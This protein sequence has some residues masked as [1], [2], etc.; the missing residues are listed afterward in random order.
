VVNTHHVRVLELVLTA[1]CNLRCSYCYQN[2]KKARSMEW[3]TLRAS[4]DLLARSRDQKVQVLFIGGEPLLEFPLIERAV[5]YFNQIRPAGLSVEYDVITNGTLMTREHIDF[6]I[7]HDFNVQVSFD[8]VSAVQELRGKGTFAVLD[9]LL[10]GLRVQ[11]YDFFTRKIRVSLT[12]LSKTVAWLADSVD[13]FLGKGVQTILISP[14]FTAQPDWSVEQIEDLDRAFERVF[15]ACLRHFHLTGEVPLAVFQ[16]GVKDDL[17]DPASMAMCNVASGQ[18]A[19]IDVDGQVLGCVTFAE[20][21]QTFPTMFL[22]NRLEALRMGDVRDSR[23]AERMTAYPAAAQAAGLFT[24]KHKKYSSYGYCGECRY[25]HTCG[26]CPT[27]IGHQPGNTDPDRVPD[28]LCAF[29]LIALKYRER[30]PRM[31]SA[32]DILLGLA[33]IPELTR[34]LER[35]ARANTNA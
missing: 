34:A 3:D 11:R 4:L 16:K 15:H 5:A 18:K 30:F 26:I 1:G 29:N 6:F 7:A 23:L 8:G 17:L 27:S 13:Y 28:F 21:Y 24:G 33:P 22:R 10:D 9:R 14:G 35:A 19:A 12:L 31:P 32:R 2:D 25:L 20:S